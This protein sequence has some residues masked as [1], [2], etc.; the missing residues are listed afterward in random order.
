MSDQQPTERM[1]NLGQEAL[2]TEVQGAAIEHVTELREALLEIQARGFDKA[3][4]LARLTRP[5]R[6]SGDDLERSLAA[7]FAEG[8]ENTL[9]LGSEILS[10]KSPTLG[11]GGA[12]ARPFSGSN[13][14]K[15]HA[16]GT[17]TGE[18]EVKALAGTATADSP[19]STT[20]QKPGR[21]RPKGSK[22]KKR[23][24]TPPSE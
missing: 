18:E 8:I 22:N 17:L 23:T 19:T 3:I 11:G 21:G 15:P 6:E 7:I 12:S 5:F 20:P 9:K 4:E 10:G 24:E 16:P 14:I 2:A 13:G 1:R